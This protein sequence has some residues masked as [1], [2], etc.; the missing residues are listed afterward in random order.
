MMNSRTIRRLI[1]RLSPL[2]F[3][4]LVTLV[5]VAEPLA[6]ARYVAP[7]GSDSAGNTCANPATPCA[8][9]AHALS[10]ALPG[11]TIHLAAGTYREAGLRVAQAVTVAGNSA[12]TTHLDGQGRGPLLTVAAGGA[13]TLDGL[14][15]SGGAGRRG[16]ALVVEA[17]GQLVAR[18]A[19]LLDNAA[20]WGGGLYLAGGAATIED[21]RLAGNTAEGGGAIFAAA[22]T[23][24]VV[25]SD[26]AANTAGVGGGLFVGPAADVTLA[27]ATI[28]GNAARFGGGA[29]VQGAFHS[30]NSLW[31]ANDATDRGGG[32]FGDGGATLLEHTAWLG[33]GAAVGGGIAGLGSIRLRNSL[34]SGSRG[35]DCA[36]TLTGSDNLLDDATCGLPAR[37]ATG[38]AADGR[39]AADSNALDAVPPGQ[40]TNAAT[41]QALA[42]D[43]R[44]EPRPA[45]GNGDG[46][47]RCDI[48]P[49]EFQP[50]IVIIHQPSLADGARFDFSG[51]LGPFTL[52]AA[53]PRR[54]FEVAPG[55]Y[56]LTQA[57]ETNWKV[58]AITCSDADGGSVADVKARA[59]TLDLDAGESIVCT[60]ATRATRFGIGVTLESAAGAVVVPF[61]GELGAFEL[62]APE[63]ADWR[64]AKLFAGVY[65]VRAVVPAG[66]RVQGIVCV[67]DRDN[68]STFDANNGTANIEL[69]AK[70]TI[71]CVFTVGPSSPLATLTIRHE[72]TPADDQD[73]AYTGDLGPFLLRAPSAPQATFSL[74]PGVYRVHEL[75]HPLWALGNIACQGDA[76]GGTVVLSEEATAAVDLDAGESVTCVFRHVRA[77]A[78]MGAITMT[79]T[80][81]PAEPVA[82]AYSG[83]LGDFTL[84]LPDSA[85]RAWAALPPGSYTVRQTPPA[86]WQ[87]ETI[88]C[89]GDGD[90]GSTLDPA[91]LAATIDLDAGESIVCAFADTRAPADSG[92]ITIVHAP[93]PADE[94][95]FR[96]RGALGSF[97]LRAPSQ[98]ARVFGGLAVGVYGVDVRLPDGWQLSA[99]TCEG[100]GD[101][102]SAIDL[103]LAQASIDLDAGEAITC[104]FASSREDIP[105]PP[106]VWRIYLPLSARR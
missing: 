46:S 34:I 6:V 17:G 39:P 104:R 70:E 52:S 55:S 97:T 36:A 96:Y 100:D 48:G 57:R 74:A 24:T 9:L 71:G 73:F 79:Q 75:L 26:V 93:A 61:D 37:P 86:G 49:Y 50:R 56:R 2:L 62:H 13:L 69:D 84:S 18:R 85:S 102:G 63:A 54:A 47:P 22:G 106:S 68:G 105:P 83:A 8:T 28:S 15:L 33:N 101:G 14:T 45:D 43:W 99:I 94:T 65:T 92:S 103:S 29:Y 5:A 77:T 90:D 40:C 23:L 38:L 95:A 82:F 20:D 58:T 1:A 89:H 35:G 30:L 3:L 19:A 51:D 81:T 11:D 4:G 60:F 88:T 16:G 66:W 21:S 78:E 76:D 98:P 12:A 80:A 87:L 64:S 31:R 44:G 59:V 10:R 53:E 72:A 67:G 91:G 25:R 42:T 7:A 41:G 32:L 27:R